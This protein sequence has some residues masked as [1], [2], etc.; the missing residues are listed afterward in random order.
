MMTSWCHKTPDLK[1]GRGKQTKQTKGVFV[2]TSRSDHANWLATEGDA[3]CERGCDHVTPSVRGG[4]LLFL[5]TR[6]VV[7]L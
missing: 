5:F 4:V 1:K 3:A 7:L 2:G 6:L